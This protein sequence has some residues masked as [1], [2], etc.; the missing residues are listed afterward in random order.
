SGPRRAVEQLD[1]EVW[2]ADDRAGQRGFGFRFHDAV[3]AVADGA[4]PVPAYPSGGAGERAWGCR[5]VGG[6]VPHVRE[7]VTEL[8]TWADADPF[9]FDFGAA[10]EEI[11]YSR[12][13][14]LPD[15]PLPD[16]LERVMKPHER[17]MLTRYRFETAWGPCDRF[18]DSLAVRYPHLYFRLMWLGEEPSQHGLLVRA[19]RPAGWLPHAKPVMTPTELLESIT[20][21]RLKAA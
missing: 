12:L 11:V 1:A 5:A 16:L 19:A 17:P 15:D 20:K 10:L 18:V 4:D 9:K 7:V 13:G 6:V 21:A 8:K 2:N 14:E 3:P